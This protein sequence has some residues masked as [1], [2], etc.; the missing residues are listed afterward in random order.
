MG[1][2]KKDRNYILYP[3]FYMHIEYDKQADALYVQI[4]TRNKRVAKS[5]EITKGVILDFNK[6]H[7]LVGIELLDAARRKHCDVVSGG[8]QVF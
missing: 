4:A 5:H 3:Q 7:Q 8:S 6:D 2:Q 1:L